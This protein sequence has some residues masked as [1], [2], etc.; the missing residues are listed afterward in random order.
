M[1]KTELQQKYS[2][3]VPSLAFFHIPTDAM[4]IYQDDGD[5][6]DPDTAPGI[7]GETVV[8]QGSDHLD[9]IGQDTEFMRALL[10]T[11]GLIATF[12]GHDHDNDW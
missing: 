4:H 6:V 3:V 7:N 12:S 9:Y 10:S 11:P 5:G 1:A 2:Q 8:H